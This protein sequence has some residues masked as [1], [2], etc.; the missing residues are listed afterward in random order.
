MLALGG[1]IGVKAEGNDAETRANLLLQMKTLSE[2]IVQ[3]K[4]EAAVNANA[5]V[6]VMNEMIVLTRTLREGSR[7]DDVMILQAL[8]AA[9]TGIYPEAMITGFYGKATARAVLKFQAANNL[10]R[11]GFV[12]PKT[13][14][15]LK[16]K[17]SN[18]ALSVE[19]RAEGKRICAKPGHLIA[20]GWLRKNGN[21]EAIIAD[22]VLP[23]GIEK[24]LEAAD[25]I[26]PQISAVVVS[27]ITASGAKVAWATDEE[28]SS[29]VYYSTTSPLNIQTATDVKSDGKVKAH[30][31]DLV[32]LSADTN[33]YII[34]ESKD[35]SGNKSVSAEVSFKTLVATADATPPAISAT[36]A[37]SITTNSAIITWTT[38]E[39]SSSKV[40][41]STTT[42]VNVQT[43]S[44]TTIDGNVTLHS[45]NLAN[46]SANTTYY[47]V[48]RSAD[49]AGNASVSAEFSFR[50]L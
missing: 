3:L 45:V 43:G 19:N 41:Y 22:C 44:Y 24:K 15:K 6:G 1:T 33:Y 46:L 39:N 23:H 18:Y 31:I 37:T 9:E 34:V 28:A 48:V 30:A 11:S 36:A 21:S 16:A 20:P 49:Q 25:A 27:N 40:F 17:L 26:A 38:N 42:P 29:H 7:G 12:G 8:L 2:K 10:E 32:N 47:V 50:T 4:A 5:Q 14:A 35:A 13:L